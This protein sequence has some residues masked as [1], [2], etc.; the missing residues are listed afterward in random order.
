MILIISIEIEITEKNL[1]GIT[2]DVG[3]RCR[4]V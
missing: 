3:A 4:N 2:N 1:N